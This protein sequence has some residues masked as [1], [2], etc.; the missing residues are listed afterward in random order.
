MQVKNNLVMFL[1]HKSAVG[2]EL[3]KT[4]CKE[5]NF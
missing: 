2:T 3:E 4:W 1:G 5:H